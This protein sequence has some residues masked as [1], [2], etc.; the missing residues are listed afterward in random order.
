MLKAALSLGS[1]R[2]T[3]SRYL[4]SQKLLKGRYQI[5]IVEN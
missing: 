3:I 4:K 5:E 1:S 2:S